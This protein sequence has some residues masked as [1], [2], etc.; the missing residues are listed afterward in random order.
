MN[1]LNLIHL[2]VS[3]RY[4]GFQEAPWL[5]DPQKKPSWVAAEMA[6]LAP[7]TIQLDSFPKEQK[8]CKIC[9]G[10]AT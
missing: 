7:G 2:W 9:E 6:A 10:W 4:P 1:Q 8:A 3:A 5:E